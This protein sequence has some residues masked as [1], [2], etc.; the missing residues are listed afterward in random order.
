MLLDQCLDCKF[1]L[2]MA[3]DHCRNFLSRIF[4]LGKSHLADS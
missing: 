1:Q 4:L 2:R 3:E